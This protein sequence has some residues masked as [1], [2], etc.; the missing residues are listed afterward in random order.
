[1]KSPAEAPTSPHWWRDGGNGVILVFFFVLWLGGWPE[2][3]VD[4]MF[5]T[6]TAIEL[7]RGHGLTNP[8]ITHWLSAFDT[9]R[10]YVQPP[11]LPY[12]LAG[13]LVV[14]GVSTLAL[15]GFHLSL[16]AATS[17]LLYHRSRSV[18][19]PRGLAFLLGLALAVLMRKFGMRPDAMAL[20]L[21]ALAYLTPPPREIRGWAWRSFCAASAVATQPF[22]IAAVVPLHLGR[23]LRSLQSADKQWMPLLLGSAA[24]IALALAFFAF[25]IG[26]EFSAFLTVFREHAAIATPNLRQAPAYFW[27]QLTFGWQLLRMV[28]WGVFV[29]WAIIRSRNQIDLGET[30]WDAWWIW[31]VFVVSGIALYATYVVDCMIFSGLLLA[32]A[33]L[34]RSK[35][36]PWIVG[37]AFSLLVALQGQ[38]LVLRMM[39]PAERAPQSFASLRNLIDHEPVQQLVVD[40]AAARFLYDFNLPPGTL[41]WMSLQPANGN[42]DHSDLQPEAGDLWVV[43]EWR[44]E[45]Y[46][47]Q[48][49]VHAP[50]MTWAGHQFGSTAAAPH[51]LRIVTAAGTWPETVDTTSALAPP[52]RP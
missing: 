40:S 51:R 42:Y 2:S 32:A 36:N 6:G 52:T 15:T 47:P 30:R 38:D 16:Q 22:F 25:A 37:T 12:V 7:S 20:F 26:G 35:A 17:L 23:A 31:L 3:H 50:R 8:A 41:E 48:W 14:T 28:P 33:T 13:W 45:Q 9:D 43:T 1:M 39:A 24:G 18:G 19:V 21:L 5:F 49:G 34:G 29:A 10:F 11:F 44:L 46:A 27:I 4:D